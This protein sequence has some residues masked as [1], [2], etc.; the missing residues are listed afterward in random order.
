MVLRQAGIPLCAN[1]IGRKL[2]WDRANDKLYKYLK[3]LVSEGR[4]VSPVRSF[5]ALPPTKVVPA[6]SSK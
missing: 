6:A 1:K 5:Y 2:G 3:L 4:L